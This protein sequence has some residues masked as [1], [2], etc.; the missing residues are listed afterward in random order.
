LNTIAR[1]TP[2]FV[3]ADLANLVNEAALMAARFGQDKVTMLDFEEAKDKVL[4]GVE[5]KSMVLSDEEKQNTAYHEAGHAICNLIVKKP[6][7]STRS[8]S[9]LADAPLASVFPPG[10]DKHSY[11][12]E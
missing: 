6:T 11:S 7:R 5:R 10:E 12:R 9:F 2:G 8:P 4:M 1:G 3:G